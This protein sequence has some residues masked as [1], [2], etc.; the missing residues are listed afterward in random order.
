MSNINFKMTT[1]INKNSRSKSIKNKNPTKKIKTKSIDA[2][3]RIK[4]K[5]YPKFF[6]K[7]INELI[8]NKNLQ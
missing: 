6:F 2:Y 1:N 7:K 5:Y 8:P 4:N 3:R